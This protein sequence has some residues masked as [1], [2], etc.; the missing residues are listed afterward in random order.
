MRVFGKDTRF[1][2]IVGIPVIALLAG[3]G[4]TSPAQ[5]RD[6]FTLGYHDGGGA[7]TIEV[8]DRHRHGRYDRHHRDGRYDR[9]DYRRQHYYAP[10]YYYPPPRYRYVPPAAYYYYPPPPPPPLYFDF[11]F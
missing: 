9:R 5:A 7:L 11:R 2:A 8:S 10:R 3:L 6:S 1:F 4:M